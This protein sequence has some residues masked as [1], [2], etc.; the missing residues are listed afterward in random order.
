MKKKIFLMLAVMAMLILAFAVSVS[1]AGSTSDAY[2]TITTIDG[3]IEPTVIDS[4]ARVVIVA[5]DG[6]YYTFPAY[7]I[8]S[9]SATF[10]WRK[11]DSVNQLLGYN[12]G[13]SDIRGKI[14]RM[15]LPEGITALNPNSAGGATVFEDARIM[16]EIK[17]PS[18]LTKI[19]DHTFN[20]CYKLATIDGLLEFLAKETTTTLGKQMVAETLWGEGVDLVIPKNVTSVP[21]RC[22]YGTKIK[23]V[24]FHEDINY[25]GPRSFQGCTNLTSVKLPS[26]LQELSSHVFASCKNLASVDVSACTELEKI[27]E[28]C[29]EYSAITS[30][31]FTPFAHKLISLGNGVF[32][33]CTKLATVIG[34]ELADNITT[35]GDNMF[36]AC[37]LTELKFPKNITYVGNNA[38]KGHKSQQSVIRIPNGVTTIGDHAF[39]R[40]GNTKKIDGTVEIYLPASLTQFTG[41]YNFEYWDYDVMYIPSGVEIVQGVTNGTLEKGVVYFYTGEKDS[42]S[43]HNTHN[44]ALLNAEWI[45]AGEFTGASP[46]KNYIVYGYNKCDA[47]YESTHLE[48]NNPCVI[49]CTR[50]GANGVMEENPVHSEKY[51]ILYTSYDATGT[52]TYTCSNEGCKYSKTEY[53]P[54]L[55]VCLGYSA[56]ENGTG[57]IAVGF[58]VNNKAITEYKEVTGKALKYG[59][60]AVLKD[61]LGNNDIFGKDGTAS[62]GVI[63]AEITNYEFA[64][65][66]IKIVGFTDEYKGT[67]LAM[68]TYVS[69]T[70]GE[71]TEYSYLQEGEPNE[72]EKYCFVSYNDIVGAPSND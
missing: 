69:V 63:S 34:Y 35:I 31:D 66:E 7:Y 30:F 45:S 68:G 2:G 55:F 24:T 4:E 43:I 5:N 17:L 61:R 60:F 12:I 56:P 50:C 15:E 36:Y 72:N 14:I 46:D 20:R 62:E 8:I 57:G 58:T 41:T 25:L 13:A 65:F 37:P 27:G 23:S 9:D 1:A 26:S 29:F 44:S 6:T 51:T 52:K 71:A 39:V 28:Y 21:E 11:N 32:N 16:V 10:A 38:F 67:K 18:T 40:D 48:D 47:F 64:A 59:V 70:D 49:N 42:L 3:E 19:G 54:A 33:Q 22:F 53:A